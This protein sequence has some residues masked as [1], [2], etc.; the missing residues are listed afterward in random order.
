MSSTVADRRIDLPDASCWLSM[1]DIRTVQE[2]TAGCC[3]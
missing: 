2:A 1:A 3:R